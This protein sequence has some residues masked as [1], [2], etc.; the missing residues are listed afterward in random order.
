[1]GRE[2]QL[3]E[4]EITEFLGVPREWVVCV[5]SGTAALHLAVEA[6]T[7]PGDEVLSQSLTYLAT[8]QA[9]SAAGAVPVACEI[10]P[11]NL[12]IDLQDVEERLTTSTKV[13]MPVHYASNPGDLDSIYDFAREYGLRVIEDASHAF[14]CTYKGRKIG[15]FGD[16]VCFSFDGIKN[17]TSGEGG[18]VVTADQEVAQYIRNARLLGVEKPV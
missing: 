5:N 7:R 15:S 18:G 14:G 2:V 12:T 10:L 11:Q 17:I 6:V 8:F 4:K 1:M 13:I 3:F 9:I 16:I